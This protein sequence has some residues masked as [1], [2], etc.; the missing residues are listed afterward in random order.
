MYYFIIQ[1]F[2]DTIY[3]KLRYFIYEIM[4]KMDDRENVVRFGGRGN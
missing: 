3:L 4:E 2:E 1:N